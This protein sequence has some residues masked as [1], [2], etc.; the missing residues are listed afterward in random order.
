MERIQIWA[1]NE[2]SSNY[3][4]TVEWIQDG[5][6][7]LLIATNHLH[8]SDHFAVQEIH[9][10]IVLIDPLQAAN[11]SRYTY[12]DIITLLQDRTIDGSVID[13]EVLRWLIVSFFIYV[14]PKNA[15]D[16]HKWSTLASLAEDE[17]DVHA[18]VSELARTRS[19]S[20]YYA[21]AA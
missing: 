8:P 21:N 2:K 16:T 10:E 11:L 15:L 12:Q 13:N 4:Y 19:K 5:L 1:F 3:T 18:T 7:R 14:T 6:W 9:K 17:S 20:D